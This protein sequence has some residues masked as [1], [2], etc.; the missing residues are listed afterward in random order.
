[1]LFACITATAQKTQRS[2]LGMT[3]SSAIIQDKYVAA[4]V[5]QQSVIGASINEV[6][7][8]RQGFQQPL[9]RV[10][11]LPNVVNNL[12]VTIYPNPV[13]ATLQI[14][15][16]SELKSPANFSIFNVLGQQVFSEKQIPKKQTS[17]D[18]SR[19]SSGNYILKID[20]ENQSFS[21]KIIKQ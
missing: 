4:T 1:M 5:G 19:L 14:A 18:V 10:E 21:T 17:L 6:A 20:I 12:T 13:D 8:V 3:G 16:D 2:S 15:F 7:G 11:S 9:L